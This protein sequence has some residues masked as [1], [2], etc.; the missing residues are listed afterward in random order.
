MAVEPNSS[1]RIL[2]AALT[3]FSERGYQ[4]T[5]T[6]EICDLAG[7]T[8]PTLYYFF[9]SKEGIYYA[10]CQ[11][12][13]SEFQAI[14]DE[15]MALPISLRERLKRITEKIFEDANRRPR[16]WRLIFAATYALD[17]PFAPELHKP[18]I[19]MAEQLSCELAAAVKT[20]ELS[21]R[22]VTTTRVLVLMGSLSEAI[23]NSLL[24]GNP[25]LTRTLAHSIID[26]VFDGCCP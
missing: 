9:K 4:A 18:Y 25:K 13:M 3:L 2:D 5:S 20:G 22:D 14:V 21:Q 16:V 24:L 10:I 8:K 19:A 11:N 15:G 1:A 17:S 7:I 26:A 23:S 6:R 12:A